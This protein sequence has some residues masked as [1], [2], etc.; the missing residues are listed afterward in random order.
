M[1]EAKLKEAKLMKQSID[2]A[3]QLISETSL[4]I[5]KDGI[6][7]TAMDPANVSMV[8]F[9]IDAKAFEKYNLDKD[10]S[11]G[12]SMEDLTKILKRVKADEALELTLAS[13]NRLEIGMGKRKFNIPLLD[14]G[15]KQTKKPDLAF[16]A[17]AE[18][19]T[20][21]FADAI[22]DAEIVSDAVTFEASKTELK[23]TAEGDG[24]KVE[25]LL[26]GKSDDVIKIVADSEARSIFP[27]DYLKKMLKGVSI[28]ETVNIQLGKD[29]P[30][31][32]SVR[33]ENFQMSYILA[34]RI[35][36]E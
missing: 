24:R 1:F 17:A 19:K 32:L 16:P 30:L 12:V 27:L 25:I 35:E 21:A 6:E 31:K 5:R 14:L 34:P 26:D 33:D 18:I 13:E 11:I 4:S 7:M 10:L 9:F 15:D 8:S 28:A 29:Y 20:G 2:A 36:N 23:L 3:S 22:S